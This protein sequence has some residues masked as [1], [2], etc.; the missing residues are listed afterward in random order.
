MICIKDGS[1]EEQRL[2]QEKDQRKL[3]DRGYTYEF[4]KKR[5]ITYKLQSSFETWETEGWSFLLHW[6]SRHVRVIDI[7]EG[8]REEAEERER[9]RRTMKEKEA[10]ETEKGKKRNRQANASNKET[11]TREWL[12]DRKRGR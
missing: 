12:K 8:A 5:Y 6:E 1:V 3:F 11:E 4:I 7:E 10:R 9:E 2:L